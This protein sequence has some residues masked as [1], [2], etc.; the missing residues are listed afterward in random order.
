MTETQAYSP[1]SSPSRHRGME[2]N[3]PFDLRSGSR[4]ATYRVK[5]PHSSHAPH[6]PHFPTICDRGTHGYARR[7]PRCCLDQATPQTCGTFS[8]LRQ[9]PDTS[10]RLTQHP[11]SELCPLGEEGRRQGVVATGPAATA[12]G[13]GAPSVLVSGLSSRTNTTRMTVQGAQAPAR[14]L[15]QR[16]HGRPST[17][18]GGGAY[19]A[20]QQHLRARSR[21]HRSESCSH[22]ARRHMADHPRFPDRSTTLDGL[23]TVLPPHRHGRALPGDLEA[24]S[25]RAPA[26]YRRRHRSLRRHDAR[27]LLQQPTQWATGMYPSR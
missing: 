2:L 16:A 12:H 23:C 25:D 14:D 24:P 4:K 21:L 8:G 11:A 27:G 9:L 6:R 5:T 20:P 18:R 3:N 10:M 17:R 26:K 7:T 15:H 13:V 1:A 22:H 19:P